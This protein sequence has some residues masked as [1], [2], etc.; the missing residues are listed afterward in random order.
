M[1]SSIIDCYV[2]KL[3]QPEIN[4]IYVNPVFLYYLIL[5]VQ[6]DPVIYPTQSTRKVRL[7]FRSLRV[8]TFNGSFNRG[9]FE[10]FDI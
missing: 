5:S 2:I 8:F 7:L 6:R 3:L 9:K 1:W 10:Y 4:V